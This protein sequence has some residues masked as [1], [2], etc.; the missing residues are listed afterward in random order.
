M[1]KHQV[2]Y[3]AQ[4]SV[5]SVCCNIDHLLILKYISYKLLHC[6]SI[7]GSLGQVV[8][9]GHWS[10][11]QVVVGSIPKPTHSLMF[12]ICLFVCFFGGIF[13]WYICCAGVKNAVLVLYQ[14][15]GQENCS[16][17]LSYPYS[18][19]LCIILSIPSINMLL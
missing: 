16:F 3:P 19:N 10:Y 9:F 15:S 12:F 18:V 4:V 6:G 5:S 8:W 14:H 13:C 2:V 17:L 11:M 1:I 7:C